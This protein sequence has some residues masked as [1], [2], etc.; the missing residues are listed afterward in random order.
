M[1]RQDIRLEIGLKRAVDWIVG[2]RRDDPRISL[3]ELIDQASRRFD[4]S[5]VQADFLYRHLTRVTPD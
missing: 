3:A 1:E 4:L 5:P 2:Q